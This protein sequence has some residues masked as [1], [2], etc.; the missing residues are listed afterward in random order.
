MIFALLQE[1]QGREITFL[2]GILIGLTN[3]LLGAGGGIAGIW[4]LKKMGLKD[5]NAHASCLLM[6]AFL[7]V[8]SLG[9]Y[10]YNGFFSLRKEFFYLPFALAGSIFGAKLL[11]KLKPV[12]LKILFAVFMIYSGIRFLVS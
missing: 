6:M 11:K 4:A 12:Y 8:I 1:R 2:E 5:K 10:F 3:S 7:S 9:I